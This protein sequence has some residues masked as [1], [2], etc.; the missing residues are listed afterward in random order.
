MAFVSLSNNHLVVIIRLSQ[1][2]ITLYNNSVLVVGGNGSMIAI[3]YSFPPFDITKKLGS[4]LMRL[5]D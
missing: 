3:L 2:L 4:L 1:T 5:Q